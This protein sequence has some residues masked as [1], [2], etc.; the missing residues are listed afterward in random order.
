[1]IGSLFGFLAQPLH[2]IP[3]ILVL[4]GRASGRLDN[5]PESLQIVLQ[6]QSVG[7]E[8]FQHGDCGFR[9]NFQPARSEGDIG[10]QVWQQRAA[11]IGGQGARSGLDGGGRLGL[12][13][14][15]AEA[16]FDRGAAIMASRSPSR[17]GVFDEL[18]AAHRLDLADSLHKV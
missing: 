16:L 17:E 18:G 5:H 4:D 3:Q 6:H 13:P 11:E 14:A 7:R 15:G 1:M 9:P 8:T 12:E 2:E 10:G